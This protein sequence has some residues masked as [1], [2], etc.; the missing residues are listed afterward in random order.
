MEKIWQKIKNNH[1]LLMVL[2]CAIPIILII[3]FTLL[4]KR[5]SNYLIWLIILLC[6]LMHFFMM[7]GHK[8]GLEKEIGQGDLYKCPECGIE[9]HEKEWAEKCEAW[10]KEHKT[11]NVEIIN[12]AVKE[13]K[14]KNV[15]N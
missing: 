6:P 2:C 13:Q 7:K 14:N 10:C 5:S 4:F 9:Y 15:S 3:G 11:C 1:L 8:H 12:H